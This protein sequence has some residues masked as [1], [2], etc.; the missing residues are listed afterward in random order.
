M[1]QPVVDKMKRQN[2]SER[3][4]QAENDIQTLKGTIAW[5]QKRIEELEKKNDK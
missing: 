1:W 2:E 3:I 5:L 4:K